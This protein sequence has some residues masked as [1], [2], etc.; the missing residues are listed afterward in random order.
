MDK[1]NGILAAGMKTQDLDGVVKAFKGLKIKTELEFEKIVEVIFDRAISKPSQCGQYAVL[2]AKLTDFSVQ[3]G[4]K[5]KTFF[6]S[7]MYK[8]QECFEFDKDNVFRDDLKAIQVCTDRN[9]RQQQI[10]NLCKKERLLSKRGL[11]NVRLVGELYKIGLLNNDL[12]DLSIDLLIL[13]ND[14]DSYEYLCVLLESIGGLYEKS[15]QSKIKFDRQMNRL[16][17]VIEKREISLRVKLLVVE[18]M[19]LREDDWIDEIKSRNEPKNELRNE[20]INEPRNEP[21]ATDESQEPKQAHLGKE[22][23]KE[24][25]LNGKLVNQYSEIVKIYL[26]TLD[27]DICISSICEIRTKE[28]T[29]QFVIFAI[30]SAFQSW[31]IHKNSNQISLIGR[32]LTDLVALRA[33]ISYKMFHK[34]C[35]FGRPEVKL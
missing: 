7:L 18:L 24:K 2:C 33:V 34:G 16:E 15:L 27:I 29:Y 17:R 3:E 1:I 13:N 10:D 26:N 5:T 25:D 23:G 32:L 19:Q 14:E 9:R 4:T 30:Q 11:G 21:D 8:C 31:I 12:I 20:S 22:L 28:N 35:V 6:V